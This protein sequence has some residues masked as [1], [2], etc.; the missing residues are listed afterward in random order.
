M[1]KN[2]VLLLDPLLDRAQETQFLLQLASFRVVVVQNGDEAFNWIVSRIDST[3][4]IDLLVVNHYQGE[5][6][7][8]SLLP[9]LRKQNVQLP[10]LFVDRTEKFACR[11]ISEEQEAMFCC[12]AENLLETVRSLFAKR[13]VT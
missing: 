3:E 5:M 4:K 13:V 1:G 6:P 2:S 11:M 8:L 7:I 12:R 10:V 9:E